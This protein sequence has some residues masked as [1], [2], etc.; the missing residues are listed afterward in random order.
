[1]KKYI[2]VVAVICTVVVISCKHNPMMPTP[3]QVSNSSGNN[4]SGNNN[5]GNGGN[6][7]NNNDSSGN[8]NLIDTGVCFQRDILPIFLSNCGQFGCHDAVTS[9]DGYQF[10]DY[11]SIV[12]RGVKSSTASGSKVYRKIT[13]TSKYDIMPPPPNSPLTTEQKNLIRDWINLGAPNTTNC[14]LKCDT[15]N[16]TFA[17][18]IKPIIYK[19][20]VGCHSG[21]SASN[22]I[23]FET[24]TDIQSSAKIGE[25]LGVIQH[26]TGYSPM[27]RGGTMVPDCEIRQIQK[28]ID[29]GML[30]N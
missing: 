28:W 30:N 19:Y 4:N 18:D 24:Y 20:C 10:T 5:N 23:K 15:N 27:P 29:A 26:K 17:A 25:L 8:N 3:S 1:M 9:S 2:L 7:G 16:F 14:A 22:G 11:A 12:K 6:T 13:A 21:P